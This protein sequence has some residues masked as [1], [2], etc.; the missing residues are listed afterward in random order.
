LNLETTP[1]ETIESKFVPPD[2][3]YEDL[4][5]FE[6]GFETQ[7]EWDWKNFLCEYNQPLPCMEDEKD[8]EADP[9]YV[10][11]EQ[12]TID[13]E[14]LRPVRVPKKELNELYLELFDDSFLF[15]GE[16]ST[17]STKTKGFEMKVSK[18]PKTPSKGNKYPPPKISSKIYSP[19]ELNTPP[20]HSEPV[21]INK[22]LEATPDQ[23]SY[24][25]HYYS[26][27]QML[28][29]PLRNYT[30]SLSTPLQSPTQLP[31]LSHLPYQ[32]ASPM[33]T[34]SLNAFTQPPPQSPMPSLVVMS[35]QIQ[36]VIPAQQNVPMISPEK[37]VQVPK[38]PS[39]SLLVINQNQLE[40]RPLADSSG[41]INTNSIM[42]QGF[43]LNGMYTLPQYQSL[44]LQVPTIDLLQNNFK[45]ALTSQEND[46]SVANGVDSEEN[47]TDD[48]KTQIKKE[49]RLKVFENLANQEPEKVRI[50]L[51][52][53]FFNLMNFPNRE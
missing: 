19:V 3:D 12:I 5:N 31:V 49:S 11:A 17:S 38:Q 30:P 24:Q 52:I 48:K 8:D 35:P 39:A 9:E 40:I 29:T 53:I 47:L 21:N 16:S 41:V 22:T 10:A 37:I 14:E 50:L 36:N 33:N 4:Y 7:E 2:I 26:P 42:S 18:R 43:Y 45:L 25:H 27:H 46:S 15:S 20:H 32:Y 44:V 1:I 34:T 28:Q 6:S 23:Q 13:K 51:N